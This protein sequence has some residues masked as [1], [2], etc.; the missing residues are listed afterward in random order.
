MPP[1]SHP[2]DKRHDGPDSRH[3]A[4]KN[5]PHPVQ[6]E[7]KISLGGKQMR[8]VVV[9]H[10]VVSGPSAALSP[11]FWPFHSNRSQVTVRKLSRIAF[12]FLSPL[13]VRF[14]PRHQRLSVGIAIAVTGR[15]DLKFHPFR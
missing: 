14:C 7:K 2:V 9:R 3:H 13:S 8:G 6:G 1:P 12:L 5:T 15:S 11:L 10:F 4:V